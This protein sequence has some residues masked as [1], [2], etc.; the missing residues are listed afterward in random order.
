MLDDI[1]NACG[2]DVVESRTEDDIFLCTRYEKTPITY[3][4]I[5]GANTTDK[6]IFCWN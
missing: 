3:K 4:R 2:E 1:F 6:I 5:T